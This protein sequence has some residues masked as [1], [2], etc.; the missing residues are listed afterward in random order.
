M[1]ISV[2]LIKL[3]VNFRDINSIIFPQIFDTL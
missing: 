3:R 2:L 1:L